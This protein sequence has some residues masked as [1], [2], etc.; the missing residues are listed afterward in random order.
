MQEV[1]TSTTKEVAGASG[2]RKNERRG[3]LNYK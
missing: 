3:E 2:R 1:E